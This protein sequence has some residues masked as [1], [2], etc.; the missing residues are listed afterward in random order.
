MSTHSTFRKPRFQIPD[1]YGRSFTTLLLW[2]PLQDLEP[3]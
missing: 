1:I 2:V 3:L